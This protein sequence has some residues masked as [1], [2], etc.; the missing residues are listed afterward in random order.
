MGELGNQNGD[1][2]WEAKA[3][4]H[5]MG[6]LLLVGGIG[7]RIFERTSWRIRVLKWV[8]RVWDE[9]KL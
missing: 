2:G 9:V 1:E 5:R 4:E 3:D 7:V 6:E 8:R